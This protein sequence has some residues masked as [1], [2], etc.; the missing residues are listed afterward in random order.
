[1][2]LAYGTASR[3]A[4]APPQMPATDSEAV[5][6]Q[7]RGARAV[8]RAPGAARAA[9][10]AVDRERHDHPVAQPH[11]ADSLTDLNDLRHVLIT[12]SHRQRKRRRAECRPR[13]H[14]AIAIGCTIAPEEF[15]LNDPGIRQRFGS[16]GLRKQGPVD[17]GEAR[18]KAAS[19][20]S[21]PEESPGPRKPGRR[22]RGPNAWESSASPSMSSEESSRCSL[23]LMAD[24]WSWNGEPV[25]SDITC[26]QRSWAAILRWTRSVHRPRCRH[27]S[28]LRQAVPDPSQPYRQSLQ[29]TPR[30]LTDRLNPRLSAAAPRPRARGRTARRRSGTRRGIR[31]GSPRG[32]RLGGRRRMRGFSVGLGRYVQ[33]VQ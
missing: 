19:E 27:R 16:S 26:S 25:P 1:M 10:P 12:E 28:P 29:T 21:R 3:S 22:A 14:V 30:G 9:R 8:G 6:R 23:S 4:M 5:H 20:P 33:G 32:G 18:I 11:I 7:R 17:G 31:V 13:S 2:P 15:V 24:L